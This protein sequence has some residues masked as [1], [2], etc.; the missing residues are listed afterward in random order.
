MK[1]CL[2]QV[3]LIPKLNALGNLIPRL[4]ALGEELSAVQDYFQG[5]LV[6]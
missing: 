3:N 4:N 1:R 5:K 6:S 2:F